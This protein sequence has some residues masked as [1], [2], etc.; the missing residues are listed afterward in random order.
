MWWIY[1]TRSLVLPHD[2]LARVHSSKIG[3]FFSQ[4][5]FSPKSSL[6]TKKKD[7]RKVKKKHRMPFFSRPK[8]KP[9]RDGRFI[10][11]EEGRRFTRYANMNG[12]GLGRPRDWLMGRSLCS[13]VFS[14]VFL[15]FF[16]FWESRRSDLFVSWFCLCCCIFDICIYVFI[17][18]L[19]YI[20]AN[21]EYA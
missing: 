9:E 7:R 10:S 19:L 18:L 16:F 5:Q 4:S 12:L 6:H 17:L 14:F 2:R 8:R 20:T 1:C 3:F 13:F 21:E 11:L 15:F